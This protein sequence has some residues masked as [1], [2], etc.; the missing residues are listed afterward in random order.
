MSL[1]GPRP[2]PLDD[3]AGYHPWHRRRLAMKPGITGLWQVAGRREVDFDRWV[4]YDLEYID[5]WSLWLDLRLLIKTIPAMLRA[6]GR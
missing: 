3:V 6:E 5:H 2:H 1:V 4:Q